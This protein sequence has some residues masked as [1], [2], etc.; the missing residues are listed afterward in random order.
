MI[1][2]I[3]LLL[4]SLGFVLGGVVF[5]L[6][7]LNLA[8]GSSNQDHIY[9]ALFGGGLLGFVGVVLFFA[10]IRKPDD[11]ADR[12]YAVGGSTLAEDPEDYRD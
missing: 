8:T 6:N 9:I 11:E 5:A 7:E 3:T 10:G 12:Y 1:R 4:L 2:K